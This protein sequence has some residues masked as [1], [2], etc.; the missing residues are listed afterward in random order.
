MISV[1]GS[2][3]WIETTASRSSAL[4]ERTTVDS[5]IG[6]LYAL[7]LRS[8]RNVDMVPPTW[9]AVRPIALPA[10]VS[11]PFSTL[12]IFRTTDVRTSQQ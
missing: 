8:V 7:P 1:L 9:W 3:Y 2:E 10:G 12:R 11:A 4:A 6:E 5:S